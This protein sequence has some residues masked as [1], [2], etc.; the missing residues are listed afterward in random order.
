MSVAIGIPERILEDI[1]AAA[2]GNRS[3]EIVR[4]LQERQKLNT[5]LKEQT[6]LFES[7]N[8]EIVRNGTTKENFLNLINA[9]VIMNK[10]VLADNPEA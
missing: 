5:V 10:T 4:R 7:V 8:V 6:K 9:F 3:A 2:D 1:D